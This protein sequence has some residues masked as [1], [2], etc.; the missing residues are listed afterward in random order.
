MLG[1]PVCSD[2]HPKNLRLVIYCWIVLAKVI[3]T[4]EKIFK[5]L[6]EMVVILSPNAAIRLKLSATTK[7]FSFHPIFHSLCSQVFFG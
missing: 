4:M 6:V 5:T 3:K 2:N 1:H 7:N